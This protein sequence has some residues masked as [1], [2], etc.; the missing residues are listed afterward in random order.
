MYEEGQGVTQNYKKAVEWYRLSAEQ[1]HTLAQHSLGN[2]YREGKGIKQDYVQAHKWYNIAGANEYEDGPKNRDIIEKQ[3]TPVQI[4][5]AQKE[6]RA[7]QG[8][9]HKGA[10]P[11][12]GATHLRH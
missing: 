11:G 4:A 10:D 7:G 1:G 8:R 6:D 12:G 3:M 2:I 5:E 9:K